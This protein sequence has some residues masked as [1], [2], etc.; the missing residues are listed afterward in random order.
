[1]ALIEMDFAGGGSGETPTLLWSDASGMTTSGVTLPNLS[2]Y[3]YVWLVT[4]SV[5]KNKIN[6][7]DTD[8]VG[9]NIAF[10]ANPNNDNAG[11]WGIAFIEKSINKVSYGFSQPNLTIVAVYGSNSLNVDLTDIQST[12]DIH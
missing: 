2:N 12:W 6:L 4:K 5:N 9:H 11:H 10:N 8:Y 3:Q 1:M 7:C